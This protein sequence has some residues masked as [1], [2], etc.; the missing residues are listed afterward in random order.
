MSTLFKNTAVNEACYG[1]KLLKKEFIASKNADLYTLRHEKTGAELLY[2]DRAD[3]NKTFAITFTTLPE[4]NTGVFHILEHS[5]L[6]GSEKHPVKEPFVSMLQSS[7]QT[8][9]NAMTF[10]D[11]TMY[12]VSSRNERDFFNLMKVYLD[13]V[14][15]P[16]IY[17][18]P[19]I[20]MQEGWHYEFDDENSEPY[21][22]GVVYSEMKGVFA[23]VDSIMEDETLRLLFPDNCYGFVSGGHPDNIPELTYEKFIATHRRFYHPTN[24]KIFLDGNMDIDSVL[25]YINDEYLSKYDYRE[26]DFAFCEQQPKTLDKTVY[27][28]LQ[29][30]EQPLSH[31]AVS[32]ILC[33][34]ADTL[35]I[36]AAKILADYLAGSN[37]APLKRAFLQNGLSK[38]MHIAVYDG[39]Y[40]PC[41][42]LIVRNAESEK[43]AEIKEF[44]PKTV[45]EIVEKGLNR[46]ALSASLERFAFNCREISEPYGVELAI[47]AMEGWLYGDDP[48]TN[49]DNGKI[50][51]ELREMLNT[52]YFER[53]LEEMFG[54]AA[55]KS[56]LTVHPSETKGDEDK[57]AETERLRASIADWDN[58]ETK[59]RY[60]AFVKMQEWQKTPD[61]EE[62]LATLPHLDIND[63]PRDIKPTKTETTET[64][65]VTVLKTVNDTNGIVYLNMYFDISDFPLEDLRILN[66]VTGCFGELRT[67]NYTADELQ[68]KI[69]TTLGDIVL[70]LELSS[71]KGQLDDCTPYL[72]V[73]ASMLEENSKSAIALIKE[74]MVNGKYDETEKIAETLQQGN[75][76]MKQALIGNG[77]SFA[78]TKALSPYSARGA[79]R[80]S[81]EGAS[82]LNWFNG[83]TESFTDNALAVSEKI[84]MLIKKAFAKNRM[85]IG[86]SGNIAESEL[87]EIINALP[88]SEIGTSQ[89]VQKPDLKNESIEIPS[90]VGFSALGGNI[91]ALGGEFDGSCSVLSSL[92]TFGYLW[93]AVRVQ[94]G[95]Y[96]TGMNIRANGDIFCYSYRDPNLRN[97]EN[98]FRGLAA[99]LKEYLSNDQKLD[100][101][102]IGTVNT[103][104]PLLDPSAVCALVCARYLNGTTHEDI[105]K[106]RKEILDTDKSALLRLADI[107]EKYC[108]DGKYCTVCGKQEN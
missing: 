88:Q 95:A 98:A 29:D 86:Y 27:Y 12:P 54:N 21:Y 96:G 42:S 62:Q 69:K 41:I 34:H 6:N 15:C 35:K 31:M 48:M 108:A 65:G 82:F 100:D 20:F 70:K 84:A 25:S 64:D 5:V 39:I 32:K 16:K 30:G 97:S 43:L 72:A 66:T 78:I 89:A 75:Y 47:K 91:Y 4:D 71:E 73:G 83:F 46:E 50:F 52:N 87:S 33:T 68:T 22:N 53:T 103:T 9:L 90:G 55:D 76:F 45:A 94:G 60:A 17:K 44:I 14:F 51:D 58:A 92:M 19:E 24:A 81:L 79:L 102:V 63:I 56:Y 85:F 11:K 28:Q 61:S 38:D 49:I 57:N 59:C 74:I 93:N 104:D 40:Q 3:E 36:Y 1:F 101:T 10:C 2:F 107:I 106:I 7:M 80:E 77:H 13:A 23:D 8:F 18:M 67:E 105:V 26:S 37:E 99:Y